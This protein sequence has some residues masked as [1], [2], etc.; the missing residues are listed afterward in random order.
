MN[1]ISEKLNNVNFLLMSRS[2][3]FNKIN[4]LYDNMSEEEKNYF[5]KK[6]IEKYICYKL[7]SMT[8]EEFKKMCV[9]S[10]IRNQIELIEN[11][12]Y[13]LLKII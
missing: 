1:N 6:Y 9:F 11:K 4:H 3:K 2:D 8:E 7:P 13:Y 10:E 12:Q 5:Y